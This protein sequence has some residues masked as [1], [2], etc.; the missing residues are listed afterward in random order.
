MAVGDI[1]KDILLGSTIDEVIENSDDNFASLFGSVDDL[2]TAVGTK[3]PKITPKK[4]AFNKD[5]ATS[6]PVMDGEATAGIS[7]MVAR[8]DHKHPTDTTRLAAKPDGSTN[9]IDSNNKID[10]VYLPD[11]VLGQVEYKGTFTPSATAVATSPRKGDYWIASASGN[12]NPDGTAFSAG[13]ATGDWAVYNGEAWDKVDNTDAVTLV[14]GQKGSVKTYKGAWASGTTY[15]QGDTVLAN[16]C[17]YLYINASA[18]SGK[19]VT[20]ATYWKIF[21]KVY[22]AATTADAG[23]MSAADKA[24]LDDCNTKK[25]THGNKALLDTYTQTETDLADTVSKKHSHANKALLDTYAQ[26]ETNLADAVSKKHAHSNKTVLDGTTASYTAA[27]KTKLGKIDDSLLD[28]TADEIGKVK[29]VKVNGGSVLGADGVA[30]ITIEEL[31]SGYVSI[32]TTDARW[33]TKTVNGTVY[34]AL[35][36]EKTDATIEVYNENN[37]KIVTQPVFDD[38]YLYICI[39]TAKI[40]C[41]LRVMG[42]NTVDSTFPV[43][44]LFNTT[45]QNGTPTVGTWVL[46]KSASGS[47]S[48]AVSGK[49][50]TSYTAQG[51]SVSGTVN[52]GKG[53]T[54]VTITKGTN[55]ASAD[56]S[57]DTSTGIAS[58]T[59]YANAELTNVSGTINY[60]ITEYTYR[61][62]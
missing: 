41:T 43:G 54:N 40:N 8:G 36:L 31:K 46:Y 27:E 28:V 35:K 24:N 49:T 62:I 6:A 2:N 7:A 12:Y 13:Y 38:T 3:E 20:N 25:H 45:I 39:G 60:Q 15:Y 57:Y 30:A 33:T 14:N 23:L 10:T 61:R 42:G 58:W 52:L 56:V 9:L 17:L 18:A 47:G 22:S 34:Q 11:A 19:V 32:T 50:G 21:G 29:D 4:T 5:F 16:E 44:M 53:L 1:K 37:Q 51:Y 26:T 48:K 55:V 59:L